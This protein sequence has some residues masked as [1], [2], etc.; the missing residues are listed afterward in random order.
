MDIKKL[1]DDSYSLTDLAIKLFGYSNGRKTKELL[2]IMKE[3]NIDVSVF[4]DKNKN[5]IYKK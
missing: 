2:S 5:K 4:D 3:N 1:I